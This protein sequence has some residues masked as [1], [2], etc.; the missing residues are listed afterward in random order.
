MCSR[1]DA[2]WHFQRLECPNCGNQDQKSLSYFSDDTEVYRLYV[3][4]KCHTYLKA[5][6]LKKA[7]K[8]ISLPVERL[9]TFDMDAQRQQKGY[10]SLGSTTI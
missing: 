4:D 7:K 10:S 8:G 1:C 6:D 9:L 5:V 2:Q 3:C